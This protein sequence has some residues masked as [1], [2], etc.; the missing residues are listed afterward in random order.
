ML[1]RV[2]AHE[3]MSRRVSALSKTDAID[4]IKTA[5]RR[6]SRSLRPEDVLADAGSNGLL[7]ESENGFYAFSHLTFQ[8]YFAAMYILERGL[9]TKLSSTV[10]D[11]W[12]RECTLLYVASADAEPIVK[13]CLSINTV[14]SL[15]LAFDCADEANEL[16][17]EVRDQLEVLRS[18]G[19][20]EDAEEGRHR[21][22]VAVTV[23]RHLRRLVRLSDGSR[24]CRGGITRE[25]YRYFLLDMAKHGAAYTPAASTGSRLVPEVDGL[26]SGIRGSDAVAFTRWVNE[27]FEGDLSFWLPT[28]LEVEE[29]IFQAIIAKEHGSSHSIWVAS[30]PGSD[31]TELWTPADAPSPLVVRADVVRQTLEKDVYQLPEA[32][33]FLVLTRIDVVATLLAN[34]VQTTRL[35]SER[36]YARDE[37]FRR[38]HDLALRIAELARER[39]LVC[40]SDLDPA[41][42]RLLGFIGA[43][44]RVIK[45]EL[46]QIFQRNFTAA[47]TSAMSRVRVLERA[48]GVRR[49][50]VHSAPV[51]RERG[52]VFAQ[53]LSQS[54]DRSVDVACF[55]DS[56]FAAEVSLDRFITRLLNFDASDSLGYDLLL[57]IPGVLDQAMDRTFDLADGVGNVLSSGL[58]KVLS[59]RD[60]IERGI[61]RLDWQTY[62]ASEIAGTMQLECP[63]FEVAPDQI[64]ELVDVATTSLHAATMGSSN[65]AWVQRTA[66]QFRVLLKSV[67]SRVEPMTAENAAALRLAAFCL[68]GEAE[69]RQRMDLV[70]N[71]YAIG[72]AV[73]WLERRYNGEESAT[74]VLYLKMVT[75]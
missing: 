21:L 46:D 38:A 49:K 55:L 66:Q 64:E 68:A 57:N 9:V 18:E 22:M 13:E 26:I 69:A 2:L 29:P 60:P 50:R 72:A 27:L 16:A 5:V 12:W 1:M 59:R 3:M 52:L 28:R 37:Q 58:A 67:W 19:L 10:G 36:N 61:S 14:S 45:P 41:T 74:E 56:D 17:E 44:K 24:L 31:I 8:E 65:A 30:F 47:L 7:I 62:F 23:A 33:R 63:V 6:V 32:L 51:T 73:T 40:L 20:S 75:D 48:L 71:F 34:A 42:V 25:I 54:L 70:E 43:S 53:A 15:S 39:A 11:P 35:Q 4:V